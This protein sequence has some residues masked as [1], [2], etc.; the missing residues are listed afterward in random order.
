M[1]VNP[2]AGRWNEVNFHVPADRDRIRFE[3][4]RGERRGSVSP[5][6]QHVWITTRFD[7]AMK[8]LS[9]RVSILG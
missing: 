1:F 6:V 5:A 3:G 8:I 7:H 2:I 4:G 9:R